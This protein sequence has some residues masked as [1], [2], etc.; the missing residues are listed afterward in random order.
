MLFIYCKQNI[1]IK[2]NDIFQDKINFQYTVQQIDLNTFFSR[3]S[4]SEKIELSGQRDQVGVRTI[5]WFCV[6]VSVCE[7]VW[8][9]V[10]VC[11]CV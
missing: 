2:F 8:V 10:S 1:N 9:C 7:Y 3:Q 4:I 11:K 6:C 5:W